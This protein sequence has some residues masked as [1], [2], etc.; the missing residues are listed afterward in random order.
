MNSRASASASLTWSLI[1][2][3]SSIA[4]HLLVGPQP[5]Q[6]GTEDVHHGQ[7]VV[8]PLVLRGGP[9]AVHDEQVRAV[10]P[11]EGCEPREAESDQPVSLPDN[12]PRHLPRLDLL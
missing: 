5:I 8:H 3:H 10:P 9:G 1:F 2:V 7:H 4:D 12:T 11:T 6:P